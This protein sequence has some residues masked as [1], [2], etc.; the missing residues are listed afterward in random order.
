MSTIVKFLF[1]QHSYILLYVLFYLFVVLPIVWTFSEIKS[2][3]GLREFSGSG[4]GTW[5][6]FSM[7]FAVWA[8][9][10][11]TILIDVLLI[12]LHLL[13]VLNFL[14]LGIVFIV[15]CFLIFY[16]DVVLFRLASLF[17]ASR[18]TVQTIHF[19]TILAASV[20]P[21]VTIFYVLW[22]LQQS[23]QALLLGNLTA[24]KILTQATLVFM[25]GAITTVI[26]VCILFYTLPHMHYPEA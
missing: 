6:M 24:T 22:K 10:V 8:L 9:L 26:I 20:A 25:G 21:V 2:I 14:A 12:R 11:L 15:L 19:F 18:T 16:S 3:I 7:V 13:T 5:A 23:S 4:Y 1:G 17:M